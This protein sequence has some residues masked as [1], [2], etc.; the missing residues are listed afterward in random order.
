MKKL[1]YVILLCFVSSVNAEPS[2][3]AT[4]YSCTKSGS[5]KQSIVARSFMQN[6]MKYY[7]RWA[8]AHCLKY[9]SSVD[10]TMSSGCGKKCHKI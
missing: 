7:K 2:T 6:P 9:T 4:T 3:L 10:K 5:T 1:L 8:L